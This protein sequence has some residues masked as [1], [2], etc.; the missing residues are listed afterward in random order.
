MSKIRFL[1]IAATVLALLNITLLFFVLQRGPRPDRRRPRT[2]VIRRLHFDEAQVA[3]YD[4]L[5]RQHREAIQPKE[6]SMRVLR[7]QLYALLS[8]PVPAQGDSL[9]QRIGQLQ[10]EIEATHFQ[11]FLGIRG[12]CRAEQ[13]A[14]FQVLSTELVTFFG[15]PR[16]PK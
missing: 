15:P 11:H 12:L 8:A 4:Q 16:P 1:T 9:R 3:A 6:D 2:T 7:G 13:L 5:I 14:D 10:M